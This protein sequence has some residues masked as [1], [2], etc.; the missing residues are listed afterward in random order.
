MRLAKLSNARSSQI[1]AGTQNMV[2]RFVDMTNESGQSS[3]VFVVGD[4]KESVSSL[5]SNPRE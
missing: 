2:I 5:G 1:I 3:G 4:S